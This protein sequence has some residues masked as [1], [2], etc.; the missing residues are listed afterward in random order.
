MKLCEQ[1]WTEQNDRNQSVS[2]ITEKNNWTKL[3][4]TKLN[5]IDIWTELDSAETKKT[6]INELDYIDLLKWAAKVSCFKVGDS[7]SR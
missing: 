4:R 2:Y 5:L 6:E 1:N 7:V 3:S